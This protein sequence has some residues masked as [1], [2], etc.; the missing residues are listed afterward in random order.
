MEDFCDVVKKRLCYDFYELITTNSRH[1]LSFFLKDNTLIRHGWDR[2]WITDGEGYEKKGSG[3][4]T[5]I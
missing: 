5:G 2:F 4:E 1:S 3:K